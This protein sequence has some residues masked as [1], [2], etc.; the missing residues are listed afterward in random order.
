MLAVSGSDGVYARVF[1]VRPK[2]RY[3]KGGPR[4]AVD[5]FIP[6]LLLGLIKISESAA[7]PE[8]RGVV[9][10]AIATLRQVGKIP[11][12]EDGSNLPPSKAADP[13]A[14]AASITVLYKKAGANLV[15]EAAHPAIQYAARLA[16]NLL[17]AQL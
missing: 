10:K 15:P 13:T 4:L 2:G 6:K 5:G 3:S 7:D 12:S 14:L 9:V 8:A 1:E 17:G 16:V 11:E